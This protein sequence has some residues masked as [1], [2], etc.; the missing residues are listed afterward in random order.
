MEPISPELALV[1]PELARR[2]RALLS[3]PAVLDAPREDVVAAA[4][5]RPSRLRIRR[6][7][8]TRT[9]AWLAVPSIALNIAYIRTDSAAQP[10][11]VAAPS[12]VV[13][14]TIAPRAPKGAPPKTETRVRKPKPTRTRPSRSGV[15][16]ARHVKRASAHVAKTELRW[17]HTARAT[18]YDV[19]LW[20]DHDRVADV[21]TTKPRVT[22]TELA[23]KGKTP[24]AAGKYLWF[25]YPLVHARPWRYGRLA[26]WGT[27]QV[28][29]KLR[30]P[31]RAGSTP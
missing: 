13:T 29:A 2:A 8:L 21:W 17:P 12:R 4:A 5:P 23:C 7:L 1:D 10:A 18:A 27:V 25:V 28:P 6:D 24:L 9:A 26:K 15:A 14:V 11:P 16:S 19:I 22:V 31:R 3:V 30:C 20:R